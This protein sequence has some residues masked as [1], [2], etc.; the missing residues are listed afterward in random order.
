MRQVP[1][2]VR[3]RLQHEGAHEDPRGG[4]RG[5]GGGPEEPRGR[6][7]TAV[8]RVR[9]LVRPKIALSAHALVLPYFKKLCNL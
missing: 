6:R 9:G 8:S 5:G 3:P 4:G 1:Q 2:E 7:L